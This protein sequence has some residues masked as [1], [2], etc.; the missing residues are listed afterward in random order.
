MGAVLEQPKPV[1]VH[2]YLAHRAAIPH[3]FDLAPHMD[4][5]AFGADDAA[6]GRGA[7]GSTLYELVRTH[8]DRQT[9]VR[10]LVDDGARHVGLAR[11]LAK[12][13]RC[14]VYLTAESSRVSYVR[15]SSTIGGE[16]WEA[17]AVDRGTGEPGEW[18]VARPPELADEVPTWFITARGRLRQSNGLVTVQIP[19]GLAFAT[20]ATFRDTAFLATRMK[21]GTSRITTLAVTADQGRFAISRFDDAGARLGGVEFATLVGASLDV[22]HPDVQVALTWPTDETA[23]ATLDVE[24][25]RLADALGRT[26]WVPQPQG[27]AFVLPG[28][29]EFAAVDEVGGPSAWRAYP[30]RMASEWRPHYGTDGD[31]RLVPLGEVACAAFDGVPFVSVPLGQLEY[32][33]PWYESVTRWDGLFAVDLAVLGDGRLGVLL[34]GGHAVAVAPRELRILW[35]DAGWRG[36]DVLVLTQPPG[37]LWDAAVA[38]LQSLVDVFGIDIWLPARGAQVW[39]QPDGRLAADGPEG[40]WHVVGYGRGDRPV[41][42]ALPA[43]LTRAPR[44]SGHY[45]APL[46]ISSVASA[47]ADA[48][49]LM[50]GAYAQLTGA[51]LEPAAKAGPV[52]GVEPVRQVTMPPRADD[53]DDDDAED[54]QAEPV[55]APVL[56]SGGPHGV[57]WLPDE[58]AVNAHPL[59]LYLWLPPDG[60]TEPDRLEWDLP[61]TELYLLAGQDPLRLTDRR[62]SGH[63][64]RVSVPEEACIELAEHAADLPKPVRAQLLEW[65]ATHLLPLPWFCDLRVTAR[66]D[67]DGRGGIAARRDVDTG[68]LAIRFEGAGHGVPGLPDEV[69]HWPEKGQRADAPCYLMLPENTALDRRIVRRGFVPLARR[70]PALAD[71]HVLMEVKVRRR[72]AIDVPATLNTLAGL[73][74]AGRLHDL[75]GLDLLLAEQ[76]LGHAVLTRCWQQGAN[77]KPVVTK[78]AGETLLDA[79]TDGAD[80]A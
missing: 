54:V 8:G 9:D 66:F 75:V 60:A 62:P 38:H 64:L 3:L 53:A 65:G 52:N 45:E 68:G 5:V 35:R 27:A 34:H 67:L 56:G 36:E 48:T 43:A 15:E 61:A 2:D 19:D 72:K 30:P 79:L 59:D 37:Q 71:G 39:G 1:S 13:L 78:F 80:T 50:P 28:C 22:I 23:C 11:E 55:P 20:K 74:V 49:V 42:T 10:L 40:A 7:V 6:V 24:L 58:P 4:P 12:S 21:A 70:K 73:P 51:A 76:D 47:V 16:L 63:L 31:G 14:D 33:R 26:V 44:P 32:L 18:L 29:G 17:I 25:M 41:D 69:V 57:A 77:G 46:P